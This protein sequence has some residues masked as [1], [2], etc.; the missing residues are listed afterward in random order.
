MANNL[1]NKQPKHEPAVSCKNCPSLCTT[2]ANNKAQNISDNI[3]QTDMSD[4][5]KPAGGM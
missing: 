2:V 4:L 1:L 5:I 3:I